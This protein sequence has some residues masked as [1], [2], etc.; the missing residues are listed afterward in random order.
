MITAIIMAGGSGERFWPLSTP[1]KPKQ[2]L[3][4]FSEKT[5]IRETVDRIL[6][7]IESE[8]IFI[9]TNI[10]QIEKVREELNDIPEENFIIEPFFK[11]T[12]A[13]IGFSCLMIKNKYKSR[14][15]DIDKIEVIVLASDHIIKKEN[16]F[17]ETLLIG[18]NEANKN[19]TIVTLGI[20]P[21]K[22]ETGYGYI[23]INDS[24]YDLNSIYVIKKFREKPNLE[25]A[26]EYLSTGRYLWNSGMFIFSIETLFKNFEKHMKNHYNILE[27]IDKTI[28]E[29]KTE[30]KFNFGIKKY[31]EE[32]EKISI[33]YGIME[34]SKDVRVIPVDI[35]WNDIGSF[36]AFDDIFDKDESMNVILASN[37]M[38][39]DSTDNIII[40]DNC[41]VSLV[42]ISNVVVIKNGND[43]L[44][45]DKDKTQEIKKL[46]KKI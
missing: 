33:D 15:L 18:A 29:E 16:E 39:I 19:G 21:L 37:V 31:F 28:R 4:I 3:R 24:N 11:D 32:F 26:V 25:T 6:P 23:E 46:L 35:D 22:P 34:H 30:K 43:I 1:E 45:I 38:A 2:L 5:M 44:V 40:S 20:K 14:N 42:G 27:K 36:N 9:A 10:L 7:I 8:N 17:R 41:R 13:A 12:A